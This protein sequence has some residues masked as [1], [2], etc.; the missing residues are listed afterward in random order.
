MHM[1]Y[2]LSELEVQLIS[3]IWR[4]GDHCGICRRPLRYQD[5]IYYGYDKAGALVIAGACCA[6]QLADT[7]KRG[8]YVEPDRP[9]KKRRRTTVGVS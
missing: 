8:M 1:V 5:L 3:L 7:V 4:D 2:Q 9:S 6:K